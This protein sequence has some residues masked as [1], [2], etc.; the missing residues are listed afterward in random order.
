MAESKI[1]FNDI[2]TQ[3]VYKYTDT[4]NAE[5]QTKTYNAPCILVGEAN[6]GGTNQRNAVVTINGVSYVNPKFLGFAC[7]ANTIITTRDYGGLYDI[8]VYYDY[9]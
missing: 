5:N 1:N 2:V 4:I 3:R 8:K 9:A 6:A 7:P